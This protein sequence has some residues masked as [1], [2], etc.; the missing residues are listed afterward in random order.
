MQPCKT[1][2]SLAFGVLCLGASGIA[3]AAS[4]TFDITA[5]TLPDVVLSE[6]TPLS[7]GTNMFV[8]A[9]GTCLMDAADP[10]ATLASGMQYAGAVADDAATSY[11]VLSGSGCVNGV[12]IPGKYRI[13]GLAGSSVSITISG[14]NGADFNFAPNSGCIVTYEGGTV[15][16]TCNSFVPGIAQTGKKLALG[17]AA[18]DAAAGQG[19]G[20]S[21]AGEII[22]TVGGTVTI[23]GVD[24]TANQAYTQNFPVDVVY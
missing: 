11:G 13:K 7:Y 15:L 2:I 18:E 22:F 10:G 9:G 24:L 8:T 14:V 21:V 6:I 4:A 19:T 5:T 1:K 16:D 3:N 17:G 12:G 23:G 20:V